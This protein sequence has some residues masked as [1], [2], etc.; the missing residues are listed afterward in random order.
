MKTIVDT[1]HLSTT[2]IQFSSIQTTNHFETLK[3]VT[4]VE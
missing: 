3:L 4:L 1:A 2:Y